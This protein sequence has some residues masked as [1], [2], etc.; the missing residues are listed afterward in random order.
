M[1]AR[2]TSHDQDC[3]DLEGHDDVHVEFFGH[4]VDVESRAGIDGSRSRRR[5][6]GD[7]QQQGRLVGRPRLAYPTRGEIVHD[8]RWEHVV[9][10]LVREVT[11]SVHARAGGAR[12]C[13]Q[14]DWVVHEATADAIMLISRPPTRSYRVCCSQQPM[15]GMWLLHHPP[16]GHAAVRAAANRAWRQCRPPKHDAQQAE[17][18]HQENCG[19]DI[20]G[21]N[22][23]QER[24]SGAHSRRCSGY[25]FALSDCQ[26]LVPPAG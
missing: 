19:A 2:R 6:Q 24:P 9:Q 17:N 14:L 16:V 22:L 25:C 8:G 18:H 3:G 15:N 7:V 21:G 1:A 12:K 20:K 5:R 4:D 10:V 26:I 23:I 13:V 11:G